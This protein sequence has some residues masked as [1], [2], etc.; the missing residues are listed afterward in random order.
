MAALGSSATP[1]PH[2]DFSGLIPLSLADSADPKT[3]EK[4]ANTG[5]VYGVTTNPLI[6]Q[7]D[8]KAC[9]KGEG[10]DNAQRSLGANQ[11]CW[12]PP[13]VL[14]CS[15]AASLRKLYAAAASLGMH[16]IQFQAW[17]ETATMLARTGAA[18]A[19]LGAAERGPRVVVKVPVTLEGVRAAHT[20]LSQAR[21]MPVLPRVLPWGLTELLRG[22]KAVTSRCATLSLRIH[23]RVAASL[24]SRPSRLQGARVTLTAVYAPHQ[25]ATAVALGAEYAAPYLGRMTDAGRDGLQSVGAMQD[26]IMSSGSAMR[27]LVASVRSVD[28]VAALMREGCDTFTLP[29]RI[30]D[31]MFADELTAEAAAAFEDAARS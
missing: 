24:A 18:I 13:M 27:L 25:V 11:P 16:E 14:S 29:P 4:W 22:C 15:P 21:G 1:S 26:M 3:W 23:Q 8:G 5:L 9:T 10:L 20:L 2:T 31:A 17:G 28:E 7:R 12:S 19:E 30:F 6:L